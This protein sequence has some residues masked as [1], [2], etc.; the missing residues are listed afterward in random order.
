MD[1]YLEKRGLGGGK[2]AA[3]AAKTRFFLKNLAR[4]DILCPCKFIN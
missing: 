4:E 2:Q 3:I 1:E